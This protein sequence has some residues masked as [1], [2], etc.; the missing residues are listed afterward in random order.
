MRKNTQLTNASSDSICLKIELNDDDKAL[1]YILLKHAG[2][3]LFAKHR[4]CLSVDYILEHWTPTLCSKDENS[5][6]AT[7]LRLGTGVHYDI[8]KRAGYN[9]KYGFF[10][11]LEN[12]YIINNECYYAFSERSKEYIAGTCSCTPIKNFLT[13]QRLTITTCIGQ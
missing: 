10:V 13:S 1:W 5:L 7:L 3:E 12:V 9:S 11:L 6:K 8:K 2:D 4:F